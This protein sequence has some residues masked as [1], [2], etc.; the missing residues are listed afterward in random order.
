M[1]VAAL[2]TSAEKQSKCHSIE[3][4]I[5]THNGILFSHKKEWNIASCSN[6]DWPREYYYA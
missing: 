2:F 6:I 1:F 5:N 3:N 4:Q